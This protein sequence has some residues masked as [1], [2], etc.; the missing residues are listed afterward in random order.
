MTQIYFIPG[1]FPSL[2]EYI[3]AMNRNRHIGNK[4]KQTYTELVAWH[5]KALRPYDTP[6]E[7]HFTFQESNRKR[8]PD[9]IVFAKKFILDGLVMAGVI[10]N[11]TQ[12]WVKGFSDAWVIGE[13]G[14][15]LRIVGVEDD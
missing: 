13:P 8:D 5:S 12:Q 10:P 2:N 11:D 6:I 7:I 3:A 1:K 14:V 15:E 9:N 4:M